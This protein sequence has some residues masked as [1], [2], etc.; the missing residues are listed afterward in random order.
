MIQAIFFDRGGDRFKSGGTVSALQCCEN[1]ALLPRL[2]VLKIF[3][4][5]KQ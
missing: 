1:L 5:Y 2:N 4:E 3:M